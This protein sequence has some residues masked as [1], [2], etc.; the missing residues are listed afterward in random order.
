MKINFS[1]ESMEELIETNKFYEEHKEE[2][3]VAIKKG[4][5]HSLELQEFIDKLTKEG[6]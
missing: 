5:K 6:K 1:K 4:I 2:I 3:Q